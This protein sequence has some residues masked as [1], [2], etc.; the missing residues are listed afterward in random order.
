VRSERGA[1][2]RLG[3]FRPYDEAGADRLGWFCGSADVTMRFRGLT[4]L[5]DVSLRWAAARSAASSAQRLRQDDAV[6]RRQ[7]LY[8]PTSGRVRFARSRH[9]RLRRTCWPARRR[10]TFQNLRLFPLLSVRENVLVALDQTTCW[11]AG[12]TR[13]GSSASGATTGACRAQA[14]ELLD[15]FG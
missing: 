4:A 8:R 9:D 1:V 12:G 6:Q 2:P 7:R 13:C 3:A 5:Q 11:R 10:R 15:R 14:D